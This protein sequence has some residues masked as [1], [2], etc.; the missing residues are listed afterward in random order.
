MEFAFRYIRASSHAYIIF[1]FP[2]RNYMSRRIMRVYACKNCLTFLHL[3]PITQRFIH[4]YRKKLY[5]R[6]RN[7]FS[8]G[9]PTRSTNPGLK[10]PSFS[11]GFSPGTKGQPRLK[12]PPSQATWAGPLGFL[13]FPFF[14]S[15]F[16]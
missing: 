5:S 7:P 12:R 13:F 14:V 2:R 6:L 16:N 3:L 11:P 4:W 15:I 9:F 8:S 1:L 10:G